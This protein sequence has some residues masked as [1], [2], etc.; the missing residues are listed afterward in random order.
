MHIKFEKHGLLNK[1]QNDEGNVRRMREDRCSRSPKVT[2][3]TVSDPP[4]PVPSWWAAS[5]SV[6]LASQ[7]VRTQP[8]HERSCVP[9]SLENPAGWHRA[10]SGDR[11]CCLLSGKSCTTSLARWLRMLHW[12]PDSLGSGPVTHHLLTT[13][14]IQLWSSSSDLQF[15]GSVSHGLV[16]WSRSPSFPLAHEWVWIRG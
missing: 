7:W 6:G 11:L 12:K 3:G 5:C 8:P 14:F 2:E 1:K 10:D 13:A 4:L 16:P 15:S 9:V